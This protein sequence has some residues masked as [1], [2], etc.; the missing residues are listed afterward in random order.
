[1][2]SHPIFY[3]FA[4]VSGMLSYSCSNSS[5]DVTPIETQSAITQTFGAKIDLT[6][7]DNYENQPIPNYIR[8]DNTANNAISNG[9]ASLGRVLFYDKNLSSNNTISCASCHKQAFAFSDEAQVSNGVNGVT[10]RHAMRLVNSRFA[11]EGRFFWDERA[12]TLEA[13]T[14]QPIQNHAEMGFSG[15]NGDGDI[16]TLIAKLQAIAY[17]QEL[18]TFVYDDATITEVRMQNAMAQ[19]VRSIQSFDS[20]F[21]MGRAQVNNDND[22]FPNF[23]TQE[24]LGK[25]L[26]ITP[27]QFN[28]NGLRTSGG[29][30]CAGCHQAPEFDIDPNSHNNGTIGTASGM[31]NDLIVTRAPSLRDVVKAD[32]TSNGP[33]MHI[34][35]S[36]NFMTVLNHYDQINLAGNNNLDQRLI[37][38]GNPQNLAM[39]QNEKDALVAFIKTLAGTDVYINSKWSDPF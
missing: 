18:F 5:N 15:A 25:Q 38:G 16:N 37:P 22:P 35:V 1:M 31:G 34:G 11:N 19:F 2:K 21:D 17:Y 4:F 36:N 3:A 24:N 12:A 26:F 14:T 33:F 30:G 28:N 9:G 39:T 8:K 23:S 27:P 20:K 13:Q 6:N 7:L 29:V 10:D 32:G